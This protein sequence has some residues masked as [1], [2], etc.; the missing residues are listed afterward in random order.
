MNAMASHP[1]DRPATFL[2]AA[3]GPTRLL[4]VDDH[5][6]VRAGMREL[7]EDE[8]DFEVVAAVAT[9]EDAM[10]ATRQ[11]PIDVAVVDYQLVGRN[12]L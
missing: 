8:S 11:N 2:K 6:A 7:L 9:A 10:A 4:V 12:G 1:H 5:A 3:R